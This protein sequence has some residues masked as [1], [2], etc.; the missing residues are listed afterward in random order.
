MSTRASVLVLTA[1]CLA[2]AATQERQDA[3]PQ[4]PR[5]GANATA[6]IVVVR[7]KKGLPVTNLA[8]EDFELTRMG[9]GRRSRM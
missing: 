3:Q 4:T 9:Y 2:P 1:L 7:D 6:I 5:F 8:R